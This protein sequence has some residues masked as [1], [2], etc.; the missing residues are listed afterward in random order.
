ME[1]RGAVLGCAPDMS[2][3]STMPTKEDQGLRPPSA[4]GRWSWGRR[5]GGA[6]LLLGAA[7]AQGWGAAAPATP[8]APQPSARLPL[9]GELDFDVSDAET[10]KPIPAKLT[11]V[12]VAG[13]P[14]P[15]L[16]H[17]DIGQHE[18]G[19]LGV[20]NRVMTLSGSGAFRVPAGRYDVYV[21]RGPEWGIAVQH[22]VTV[23]AGAAALVQA[24]LKRA[25]STAGW[26]SADLH[27]HS[28]CST[29]SR[30]PMRDRVFEFV[31]D[32][33]DFI[34][35]TDH[36]V[37]C[38]YAPLIA[39]AGV[40]ALLAS[41]SGDELTTAGWGHFG[42][43]PLPQN[44]DRAGH[45][46]PH[47]AGRDPAKL[48]AELRAQF[49]DAL[50]NVHH[51]RIDAEIGYFTIGRFDP[52][53]DRADRPGFSLYFDALEVLNGYQDSERRSVDRLI[54]DWFALLN[55][56]HLVTATGNSDTHHQNNNIGGYPRNYIALADDRPL[57]VRAIDV[58][59]ALKARRSFFTTAPFVKLQ[60][61]GGQPGDLVPLRSDSTS[62]ELEV[63]A[64]PW[65]TVNRVIVYLNGQEAQRVAVPPS[66]EPLRLRT[67]LPIRIQRD[68]FV[69]VRVDGDQ[70]LAPIVG[71]RRR[72]DVRPLALTNPVFLD[73][74][75]NGRFDALAAPRPGFFRRR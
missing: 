37:V 16:G 23:H 24:R 44:P 32:G 1:G 69:V 42:A 46:A 59:R 17:G 49:P 72:F 52:R 47:L 73:R 56:G 45:G 2:N 60:V 63:L 50:L 34:V 64:A 71:D 31:A 40:G 25:F 6:L 66:T 70:P 30:V 10:G 38:D 7:F 33:I 15:Q 41:A 61:A 51:P 74:D 53:T 5:L 57:G 58:A 68:T 55:H 62:I 54:D 27:V 9:L 35:A 48:F 21:S 26:L 36:N 22:N 11:L 19:V 39:E 14:D 8:A 75:G 18:A 20:Y 3:R 67:A 12:G 43:F 4:P 29:D 65:V 13:T 28:A